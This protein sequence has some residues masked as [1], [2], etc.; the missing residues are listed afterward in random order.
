VRVLELPL[1]VQSV[2]HHHHSLGSFIVD[3]HLHEHA[4]DELTEALGH[5]GDLVEVGGEILSLGDCDREAEEELEG[6]D[7]CAMAS[8]L[9]SDH[10]TP[11]TSVSSLSSSVSFFLFDFE[12]VFYFYY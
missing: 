4:G 1:V 8:A 12:S 11:P 3:I 9:R 5:G 6:V 10:F 7:F 2:L